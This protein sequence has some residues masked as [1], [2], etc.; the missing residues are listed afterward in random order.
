MLLVVANM[1]VVYI[2]TMAFT[3]A[4]KMSPPNVFR[5]KTAALT[6]L[7]DLIN[8]EEND[9]VIQPPSDGEDSA[10]DSAEEDGG[11]GIENLSS[12]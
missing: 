6:T 3:T 11:G 1:K 7:Y 9:I 5:S 2:Y 8:Q 10:E 4:V 12:K